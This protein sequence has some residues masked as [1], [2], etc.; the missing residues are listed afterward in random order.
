M[1]AHTPT[2]REIYEANLKALRDERSRL[3]T[4]INQG[5]AIGFVEGR[6][7]GR[8]E[9]RVEGLI[10][11]RLEGLLEGQIAESRTMLLKLGQLQMGPL[12]P[13]QRQRIDSIADYETLQRC[14]VLLHP[15][16]NWDEVLN[17]VTATAADN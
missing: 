10:E 9:G 6:I 2:E 8:T 14:V 15:S 12:T 13:Q 1:V 7:E 5:R 4:A 16:R 11:G 3:K 17:E